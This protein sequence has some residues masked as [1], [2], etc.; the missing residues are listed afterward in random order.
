MYEICCRDLEQ[1]VETYLAV[2]GSRVSKMGMYLGLLA[3]PDNLAAWA[4]P[5]AS[6]LV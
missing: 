6:G 4:V 2:D 5:Q 3:I 1:T